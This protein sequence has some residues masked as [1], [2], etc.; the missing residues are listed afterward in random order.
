[1]VKVEPSYF[2][3]AIIDEQYFIIWT[4]QILF[5]HASVGGYLDCFHFIF[6]VIVNKAAM[7]IV[8]KSLCEH[9]FSFFLDKH[10]EVELLEHV[11]CF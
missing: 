4:Q 9:M 3:V 7:N 1:M 8:Y 10:L 11:V 5:I 2:V 6:V